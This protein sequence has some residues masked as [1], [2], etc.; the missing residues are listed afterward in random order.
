M[1]YLTLGGG[2]ERGSSVT[3]I[4]SVKLMLDDFG[5][6][7]E[8]GVCASKCPGRARVVAGATGKAC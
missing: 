1:S 3:I 2:I 7:L 8:G 6:T 4:H 5:S